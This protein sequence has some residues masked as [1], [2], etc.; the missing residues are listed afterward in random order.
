MWL[1]RT[2]WARQWSAGLRRLIRSTGVCLTDS[3]WKPRE[4]PAP[5]HG[6]R[7]SA[8]PRMMQAGAPSLRPLLCGKNRSTDRS[9]RL[10]R[11]S[12]LDLR[13][14]RRR[15]RLLPPRSVCASVCDIKGA[16]LRALLTGSAQARAPKRTARG[17][18][19]VCR[20]AR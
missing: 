18:L 17:F 2:S 1:E 10:L 4:E 8:G 11:A 19:S 14:V 6:L 16:C 20:H 5:C 9:V 13:Q 12:L 3:T 7:R 15:R